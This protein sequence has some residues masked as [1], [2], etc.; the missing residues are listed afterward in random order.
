MSKSTQK[1]INATSITI[2]VI[3]SLCVWGCCWYIGFGPW[4]H[5][6]VM[7]A[8]H[9]WPTTQG[10]VVRSYTTTARWY[11]SNSQ[12]QTNTKTY[13]LV[14]YKDWS[15]KPHMVKVQLDSNNPLKGA[16]VDVE[17]NAKGN[18]YVP[19]NLDNAFA[20]KNPRN[21]GAET[22]AKGIGAIV[23][24]FV[25]FGFGI[26]FGKGLYKL[27]VAAWKLW[28][29]PGLM[30]LIRRW[31]RRSVL[32]LRDSIRLRLEFHRR[33]QRLNATTAYRS[34]R[35]FQAELDRMDPPEGFDPPENQIVAKQKA[36]D[37]LN[38][39]L[40]RD[41]VR[42]TYIGEMIDVIRAEVQVDLTVRE[43]ALED[44]ETRKKAAE[45]ESVA[46]N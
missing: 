17:V 12:L 20:R 15:G 9:R 37:L 46:Q 11:G 33:S 36:A 41:S 13:T 8:H 32:R 30:Q 45:T 26:L 2:A 39:V 21:N 14:S 38:D 10:H 35:M 4:A 24:A 5:S 18:T 3:A 43:S 19:A 31:P 40:K 28:H 27:Q 29:K 16:E 44:I 25:A 42:A 34:V 1:N 23:G 22:N 7:R 6:I